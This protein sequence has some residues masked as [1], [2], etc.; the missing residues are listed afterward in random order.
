[1]DLEALV[2]TLGSRDNRG[3]TDQRIMDTRVRHQIGLEL[4]EIYVESTIEPQR[5]G[6]RTDDLS[7]QTVQVVVAR[8]GDIQVASANIVNGLVINKEGTIRVL[9]GAVSRENSVIGL[10]N[11]S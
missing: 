10:H 2:C 1:M 7:N 6:D 4:V 3:V 5:R 9:N 11:S 8:T